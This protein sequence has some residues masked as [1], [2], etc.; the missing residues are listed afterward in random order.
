MEKTVVPR[1]A[2]REN[3]SLLEVQ[4]AIRIEPE[5]IA[6]DYESIRAGQE[7]LFWRGV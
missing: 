6:L 2:K 4:G 7:L 3:I 1:H 5:D